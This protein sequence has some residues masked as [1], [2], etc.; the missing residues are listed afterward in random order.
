[1]FAMKILG[2]NETVAEEDMS[3]VLENEQK[4][5]RF[6]KDEYVYDFE[7]KGEYYTT[8]DFEDV[9]LNDINKHFPITNWTNF[10]N[11]VL[12]NPNI[13]VQGSERVRFPWSN[14]LKNMVK[15]IN[16]MSKREQANLLLWRIFAKFSA[17]FLKTG[18]EEGPIFESIFDTYGTQTSRSDNCV[19]SNQ[20][21]LP[22]YC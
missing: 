19:Q 7:D 18:E 14:R 1:M 22:V 15:V 5:A 21:V 6:S 17:N 10:V 16:K 20:N 12:R 4:L 8:G 2:A 11:N 3:K 9:S 13:T